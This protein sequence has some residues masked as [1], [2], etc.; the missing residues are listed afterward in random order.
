MPLAAHVIVFLSTGFGQRPVRLLLDLPD[1]DS[2]ESG[3]GGSGPDVR[4][5][6]NSLMLTGISI[7]AATSVKYPEV[8]NPVAC[9]DLCRLQ[10]GCV[11]F[12]VEQNA[13]KLKEWIT[14]LERVLDETSES[15]FMHEFATMDPH[16][17]PI[18][19]DAMDGV[20][21][22]GS[23]PLGVYP[24][25]NKEACEI[26]CSKFGESP[27]KGSGEEGSGDAPVYSECTAF[28]VDHG[29]C[30]LFDSLA[31]SV[32]RASAVGGTMPNVKHHYGN[33][34]AP[35]GCLSDE[36]KNT[37][38]GVEG[39]FCSP[40][41]QSDSKGSMWCP[42]DVPSVVTAE[43]SCLIRDPIGPGMHCA[44][45]C[46]E[47]AAC[48]PGAVCDNAFSIGICVNLRPQTMTA[49]VAVA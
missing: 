47:D 21:I 34:Y 9:C 30:T 32:H 22:Q 17:F 40:A 6:D 38:P 13:C 23:I 29:N 39:D 1:K 46:T 49:P 33:P 10:P 11:A 48:G 35:G 43:P 26:L 44:L 7:R 37:I 4:S 12:T 18:E 25:E 24:V 16:G 15:G 8:T 5:C 3:S 27:D 31:K 42:A 36:L 20:A 19:Y 41:C 14:P 2:P 28:T 45:K